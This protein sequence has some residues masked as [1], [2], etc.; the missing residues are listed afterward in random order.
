MTVKKLP[1]GPYDL[2]S[3]VYR[4]LAARPAFLDAGWPG[5]VW[6]S[7][8]VFWYQRAGNVHCNVLATCIA[9][10]AFSFNVLWSL[11]AGS[12]RTAALG[13]RKVMP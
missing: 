4:M 10:C 3:I 12:A 11:V 1:L 5:W 13:L 6:P 9:T 2:A 8:P 7:G